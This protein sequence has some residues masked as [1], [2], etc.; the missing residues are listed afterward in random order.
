[1]YY[2]KQYILYN[3]YYVIRNDRLPY[4]KRALVL[5]TAHPSYMSQVFVILMKFRSLF[6]FG[7]FPDILN[8]RFKCS[9]KSVCCEVCTIRLIV[10]VVY[11]KVNCV[12]CVL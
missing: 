7:Q 6:Y 3:S 1:M 2:Y 12:C 4:G 9:I 5:P 8:K 11:Y 10:F